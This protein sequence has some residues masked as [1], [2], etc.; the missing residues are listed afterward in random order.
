LSKACNDLFSTNKTQK[1]MTIRKI[2]ST[3]IFIFL[4]CNEINAQKM[5]VQLMT[6][7]A[8]TN[9]SF[10]GMSIPSD[11]VIWLSG[12]EGT[13]GKSTDGGNSWIWI[14]VKG[15]EKNDF[16]D[17]HAFDSS[18]AIIM[19]VGDPAYI[20]KTKDGGV[21]WNIV[22]TKTLPGIF[23]DAMDF[24]NSKE[25]ICIGDPIA[26]GD[27][28]RKFFYVLKTNDGGDSWEPEPLYKMPPAQQNGEAIFAASGTNILLIEHPEYEYV[29]ATGGKVSNIYFIAK[30]GKKN[31]AYP[32]ILTQGEDSKGVFSI[33]TD[34]KK[35][36]Y[37]MG[38][39]FKIWKSAYD[40]FAWTKIGS[41]KWSTPS[42]APPF[43]YRSCIAYVGGNKLKMVAC[44]TNGVDVTKD[45]GD[46]WL[47]V[48]TEGFNVCMVSPT[49]K[50][51]FLAG[52]KGKI[53][54]LKY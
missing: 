54:Q 33:T 47:S 27:G 15:Y 40:N 1:K 32:T 42:I 37:C 19:A 28:G 22:F 36:I 21:T 24:K 20:L 31:K 8:P 45:G 14:K 4:V 29:F 35:N 41:E 46:D 49:K 51:V 3:L 26:V 2:I 44:G 34:G 53:G 39:D 25:G 6:T 10:R 52:E 16:R 12:S 5:G 17:I 50:L 30:E 11:D 43:G 38:G 48:T 23:L 18:T 7:N 13:V 9:V